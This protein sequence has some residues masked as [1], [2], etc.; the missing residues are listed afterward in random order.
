MSEK[1][2]AP[3]KRGDIVICDLDHLTVRAGQKVRVL[4]CVASSQCGSGWLVTA[5]NKTRGK[6]AAK[7]PIAIEGVDSDWFRPSGRIEAA[8]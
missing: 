1:D 3:F 8:R 4:E 7:P 5:T 2:K 6:L